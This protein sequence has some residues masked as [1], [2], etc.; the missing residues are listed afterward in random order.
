MQDLALWQRIAAHP[1]DAPMGTAPYSVKLAQA[2]GWDKA[3]TM[4]VIEEYRR[5]VYLAQISPEQAT[6][7]AHVDRAWHM[8]LTFTRDYWEI[9][10][11][12]VLGK[13]LHH[14]PC[15]GEEDMP[16]YR[17]QYAATLALYQREFGG[18]PNP[19]VWSVKT[20]WR[21]ALNG[22]AIGLAGVGLLLYFTAT[23]YLEPKLLTVCAALLI[24]G[25]WTY[26]IFKLPD[27]GRKA[28]GTG[29]TTSGC[30]GSAGCGG[31]CGG[32]GG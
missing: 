18:P 29:A 20:D 28:G 12:K 17:R 7:S 4:Q 2:E 31:G 26:A 13:A 15:M 16:R 22:F 5:F 9:F 19:G 23:E 6:P 32:C 1:L 3:Y 24:V 30:G 10:C 21:A 8:H 14:E 11:P 27:Q 25:G